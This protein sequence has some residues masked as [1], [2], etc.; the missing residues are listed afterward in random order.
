MEVCTSKKD[1]WITLALFPFKVFVVIAAPFYF[2]F[3]VL[4]PHPLW[5]NVGNNTSIIDPVANGLL[6]AFVLCAPVLLLGA[7][8]QFFVADSKA[9]IRTLFFAAV[10]TLVLGAFLFLWAVAHLL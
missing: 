8:M 7:V 9:G 6:E 1:K 3:R 2:L 4:Y 5:T 10:P